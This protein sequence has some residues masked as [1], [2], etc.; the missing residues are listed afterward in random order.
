[1]D[2]KILEL[3][4]KKKK[5]G[6]LKDLLMKCDIC[7]LSHFNEVFVLRSNRFAKKTP[8]KIAK[9]RR[10]CWECAKWLFKNALY[11]FGYNWRNLFFY[12]LHI[13]PKNRD[14]YMVVHA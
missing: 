10:V 7:Y 12:Q 11:N 3:E 6:I 5:E 1:M 14:K 4:E 8:K 9:A 2:R 13:K